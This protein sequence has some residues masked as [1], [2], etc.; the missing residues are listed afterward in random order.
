[1]SLSISLTSLPARSLVRF[2]VSLRRR[3]LWRRFVMF[4][5][6]VPVRKDSRLFAEVC[7]ALLNRGLGV[8]FRARGKS[9]SPN[10]LDG[11]DVVIA[12]ARAHE[13]RRGD[14]VLAENSDGL[15]VHRLNSCD[16]A[17]G[18]LVLKSDTGQ[19]NDLRVTRIFGKVLSR[20]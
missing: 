14:I 4:A 6:E 8:R 3:V 17:T 10:L 15:C 2:S 18:K 13:L 7:S 1:D 11:D 5:R 19:E 20:N 16:P 12:P 9:M